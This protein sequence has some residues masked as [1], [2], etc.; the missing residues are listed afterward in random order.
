MRGTPIA[1]ILWSFGSQNDHRQKVWA[2]RLG[3]GGGAKS[4]QYLVGISWNKNILDYL[5]E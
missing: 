5:Q 1:L 4:P 3:W 2:A